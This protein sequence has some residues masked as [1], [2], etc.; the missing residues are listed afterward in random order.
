M[1][2]DKWNFKLHQYPNRRASIL[3]LLRPTLRPANTSG[4]LGR[5]LALL[6]GPSPHP[7]DPELVRHVRDLPDV[8]IDL[9]HEP[10]V[11]V[12][13]VDQMPGGVGGLAAELADDFAR[14]DVDDF[15][16]L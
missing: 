2:F 14:R 12:R 6:V 8:K 4:L 11:R 5:A 3:R 15:A 16:G 13:R 1:R 10:A 7:T 9:D